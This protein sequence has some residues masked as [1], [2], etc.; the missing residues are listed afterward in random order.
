[1]SVE[2]PPFAGVETRS[3]VIERLR[4]LVGRRVSTSPAVLEQHGHDESYHATLPPDA[5]V[6]AESTEEVAAVLAL[7]HSARVPVVPFGAG[8]SL[9]GGV[10]APYGGI[11]LD[12]T[13]M[14]EI[15]EI[16]DDD[17][18]ATVQAGVTQVQLNRATRGRGL[19]FSVDPGAEATLGGMCAT[20]ASGTTAVRYG[21]M[22]DNVLALTAVLADGTVVRTGGRAR[23]SAAGYDLT[24]LLI[25][26][27]GTLAVITEV[28]VRL[29][30]SPE[31]VLAATCSFPDLASAVGSV[32]A[33]LHSGVVPARV[34]LLDEVMG[35]AVVRF[36]GPALAVRPAVFYEL[37]GSPD[38]VA[39]QRRTV[40]AIVETHGG[41]GFTTAD[42][43][44]ERERLWRA[45]HDALP[46][47][48]A[49]RPGAE[50]WSTD[51]CVPISRLTECLLETQQDIAA[52]GLTAP[53]AGHVGDGNFHLAIVVDPSD[54]EEMA[55]AAALNDRM[56]VRALGMGGTCSGEHGVG[57]GKSDH[58]AQECGPAL[59]V[60]RAVKQA[61]DP[62]GVLNPGKLFG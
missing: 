19:F 7:C 54:A 21:T 13:G 2:A 18:D 36:G 25:G 30:P 10:S 29:H 6:F 1:V 27:E 49:L 58:L 43:Q 3:W 14:D 41:T 62:H 37:H 34:E 26:S 52:S 11:S 17:L 22:R 8:T 50:T 32:V 33:L 48:R 60:M 28:V 57:L 24:R 39:E 44:A 20:R 15:V 45:R 9:E 46:A 56:V 47:A 55:R 61:L 5:V 23:K 42:T 31:Q 16:R 35:D 40:A 53:I 4:E 51:V 59:E 12:L 38:A